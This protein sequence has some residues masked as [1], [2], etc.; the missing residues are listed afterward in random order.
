MATPRRQ[1]PLDSQGAR[2]PMN[3]EPTADLIQPITR[4]ESLLGDD[5]SRIC[6]PKLMPWK[7]VAGSPML[8]RFDSCL[9]HHSFIPIVDRPQVAEGRCGYAGSDKGFSVER[10]SVGE[11]QLLEPLSLLER[12]LHPQVGVAAARALAP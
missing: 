4:T 12:R 1:N 5:D 10:D 6:R 7:L 11:K 8:G 3:G 9:V 2:T